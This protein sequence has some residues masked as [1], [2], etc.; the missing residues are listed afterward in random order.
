MTSQWGVAAPHHAAS[1]AAA[2]V[3]ASG[4]NAVDAALAAATALT[5]VYPHQCSIGGDLIALVGRP[6]GTIQAIDGSGRAPRALSADW[7][8]AASSQMPV[9]GPHSVTVPGIVH[10]WQVLATTWGTRPLSAPLQVAADLADD[11]VPT[12]PGLARTIASEQHRIGRDEGLRGLLMPGGTPLGAGQML[13]QPELAAS[14]R[15]LANDPESFY[16]GDIGRSVVRTL[17]AA[18]SLVTADDFAEHRTTLGAGISTGYAGVEYV[19]A[20]PASQGAFF[21]EGLAALEILRG[22]LGRGLDPLGPDAGLV[23]L[24]LASAARDRDAL[25]AD[26][27]GSRLDLSWLLGPRAAEVARDARSGRL[28]SP[29]GPIRPSPSGTGD[30]VA[31]VTADGSGTW[32]SLIQSLFE[33]FGSGLMDQRTGV[34]LHNRGASFSLEP[35]APD[36]LSGGRRP[37]HTLMPVLLRDQGRIVGAHG[38]MGG[39]AQPQIHTLLALQ[40][41]AGSAAQ[42]AV[43]RPRWLLGPSGVSS[44]AGVPASARDAL[45][46]SGFR[47]QGLSARD[48]GVGHAQLVRRDGEAVVAATDPRADGAAL[49]G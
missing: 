42:D 38:T 3:L 41:A 30:T 37:P 11:G 1:A 35:G 33:A 34:I 47:L 16:T 44:E 48:D 45:Q 7:L 20:P 6:D 17:Q 23:A 25:W 31:I 26:P 4:G 8:R 14:L 43:D 21:L 5:V 49:V 15:E 39:R 12:A 32:V 10:A 24:V 2:E 9:D 29:T 36:Q 28:G 18:G 19:T 46:R 40:L 13:R 22:D 27:G